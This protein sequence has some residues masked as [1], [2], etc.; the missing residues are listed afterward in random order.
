M[1]VEMYDAEFD[2]LSHFSLDVVRNEK[3]VRGLRLEIQGF[4]RAFRP[5]THVD[6]LRLAVDKSLHEKSNLSMTTGRGSTLG[7]TLRDLPTCR[8]CGISHG[9]RCLEGSGKRVFTTTRQEAEQASTIV[10][11]MLPIL[12]HFAFVLFDS[13]SSHSFISSNFVWQMCL[14]VKLLGS[15]LSVSTSSGEVMLSKDKIKACEVEIENHVLD[16]TLLVLDLR[17]FDVILGMDWLSVNH[18]SIDYSRKERVSVVDTREPEVSLSSKP[19]VREYPDVFPDELSRLPPPREI[20]FAIEMEP[21]TAPISKAPYRMAPAELQELK[22][23]VEHEEHL[24]KV[25]ETLRANKLYAK[26]SK[27][28]FWLKKVSF[29]GHVVS[30]EGVSVDPMKIEVVTSLP[31]PSTRKHKENQTPPYGLHASFLPLVGLPLA[32]PLP[33]RLKKRKG[34]SGSVERTYQS[35]DPEGY[36]YQSSDPEG[37]IYQSSAI[38]GCTYQSSALTD[39]HISLVLPKD[40]HIRKG[41]QSAC[42]IGKI[43]DRWRFAVGCSANDAAKGG[44]TSA[45]AVG[46]RT[47]DG[48]RLRET[49]RR[50]ETGGSRGG[51]NV[52]VEEA[53][54]YRDGNG[55]G[56]RQRR[57]GRRRRRECVEERWWEVALKRKEK[58]RK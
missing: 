12:G 41:S 5:T 25:L 29:L 33:E 3:F 45:D 15:I 1:T 4:V 22:I 11:D 16:V 36:T 44:W 6:S 23:E 7:R 55:D 53:S 35:R 24:N 43:R 42:K 19:V 10:T 32:V 27:C 40:A 58:K 14:E 52:E 48:V 28:E 56:T 13:G 20:D 47:H 46:Q 54:D 31:R 17:D 21:G 49:E 39:A 8:C 30:S 18:A 26:F 57:W 2:M 38:E 50:L 37:C 34:S 9:G 51:R